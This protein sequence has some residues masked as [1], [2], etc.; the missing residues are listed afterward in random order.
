MLALQDRKTQS[1]QNLALKCQIQFAFLSLHC[2]IYEFRCSGFPVQVHV[3]MQQ[4]PVHSSSSGGV[5]RRSFLAVLVAT[6]TVSSATALLPADDLRYSAAG[7]G[8]VNLF[9]FPP[10]TPEELVEAVRISIRLD[11]PADARNFLRQLLERDPQAPEMVV[12]RQKFGLAAFI[13]FRTDA[14]LQPEAA[15]VLK[16][17]QATLPKLSDADLAERAAQLGTG[18]ASAETAEF[19]LLAAGAPAIPVLLS[20]DPATAAGR[21]AAKLLEAH[22]HDWRHDLAALLPTVDQPVRLRIY[23]LLAGSAAHDLREILLRQ[24]FTA[25]DPAEAA[26]AASALR[27]IAGP[28]ELPGTPD[29]AVKWLLRQAEQQ[30]LV[31]GTRSLA[32]DPAVAAV[33][34]PVDELPPLRRALLLIEHA[35]AIRPEHSGGIL[36][37]DVVVAAEPSLQQAPAAASGARPLESQISVLRK[38]LEL[39]IAPAAISILRSLDP[40]HLKMVGRK[41][42]VLA[43]LGEALASPDAHVRT[44]AA[45][46]ARHSGLERYTSAAA[47]RRQLASAGS[48]VPRPEAV[49]IMADGQR[50]LQFKHLLEDKGFHANSAGTGPEGFLAA[51]AQFHCEYVVLSLQPSVWSPAMTIANLRADQRTR[52]AT[53]ILVG[54]AS[55]REQATELIATYGNGVFL[56]EPVGPLTFDSRLAKLRLPAPMISVEDR[57]ALQQRVSALA[58]GR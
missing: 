5:Q 32:P 16:Q 21:A 42:P 27:R 3:P 34:Q 31:S 54:P 10:Q 13:D 47:I 36:L 37:R 29:T 40:E 11:R 1:L 53:L 15:Q 48:C 43:A 41:H 57:I 55:A 51:A 30:I 56:E 7:D 14:R 49:V 8:A 25:A 46:L 19:D 9:Q 17:M 50:R 33:G 24:Q 22:S 23:Q 18:L 44:L 39:G 45:E 6:L 52:T 12:L 26:A 28:A 38:A 58:S 2:R 4:P 20:Q 35:L